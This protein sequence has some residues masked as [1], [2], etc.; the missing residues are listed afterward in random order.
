MVEKWQKS[1]V[2]T[3]GTFHLSD[4]INIEL[5]TFYFCFD[6]NSRSICVNLDK[7]ETCHEI[8]YNKDYRPW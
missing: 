3:S 1:L 7:C 6:R 8:L 4:K 5:A 2:S